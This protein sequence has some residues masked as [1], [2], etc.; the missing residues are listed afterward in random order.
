MPQILMA[1]GYQSE[2]MHKEIKNRIEKQSQLSEKQYFLMS[3]IEGFK[4]LTHKANKLL[5]HAL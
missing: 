2:I 5:L 4:R 1:S 3:I